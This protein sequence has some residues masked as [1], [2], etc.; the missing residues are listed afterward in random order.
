M[1]QDNLSTAQDFA[2]GDTQAIADEDIL[3]EVR[4]L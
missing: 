2:S 1:Q 3:L 4:N